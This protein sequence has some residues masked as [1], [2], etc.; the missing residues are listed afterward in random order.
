[1]LT[2]RRRSGGPTW[3]WSRTA[4]KLRSKEIVVNDPLVYRGLRFYQASY[5]LTGKLDALKVV[6]TPEGGAGREVILQMNEPFDLDPNTSVTVAEFIPDFFIRDNQ[7]FKRSDD[8]VNPAFRL[9]I[10]NKATG[11]DAVQW[12]FPA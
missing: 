12:I 11:D 6:A 10:K 2:D 8:P 5:G 9:Q 1:M 7:V 4:R 3:P